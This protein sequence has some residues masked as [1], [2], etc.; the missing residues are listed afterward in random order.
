MYDVIVIGGGPA[1][2]TAAMYSARYGLKTIFFETV[3]PVSQLSLAPKIEN[4][5]GF[6]GSGMEL[7]NKMKEQAIKA[8]AESMFEKVNT[9]I[10]SN[11]G[12]VVK[13]EN[14]E[15]EIK[16][17]I[18]ATGG[19]HRELGVEGEKEFV[20]KGVSYCA[21]CDGFFFK[22]KKVAVIGGGNA[23]V[24]EAIYL[25]DIGC[26][27]FLIHRRDE[28]RA[29]KVM[30]D[31]LFSKKIPVIWNSVVKRIEGRN[32][33]E[34]IVVY[35]KVE[36]KEEIINVDA[37]FIAIG[38]QPIT[39]IVK[40]LGVKRD[41]RGYI[42]VDREQKTNVDGVFAAGDCCDN[43]LNQVVTACGSGAVAARSAYKFVTGVEF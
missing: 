20:G 34:R 11:N 28:L 14:G 35:N 16:A 24:A 33:V 32:K 3:D 4:Y 30:Q 40:D 38:L 1:G 23:A 15:Y 37:V 17:I 39:E 6:E 5:P 7:L 10:K 43:P 8:G 26:N 18:V 22:G 19:K 25:K 31:T 13:T 42:I 36:D 21:T 12:F 27:V 9:I 41:S 2:L 29:D